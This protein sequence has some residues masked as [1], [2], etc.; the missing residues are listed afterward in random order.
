MIDRSGLKKVFNK[1][2]TRVN[3]LQLMPELISANPENRTITVYDQVISLADR[4]LYLIGSGK[5]STS[6]AL[7]IEQVAGAMLKGGMVVSTPDPLH[8]QNYTQVAYGS[9]PVP[10]Q[11]SVAATNELLMFIAGI[12]EES[13]VLNLVSGGTSSLL[14]K[15]ASDLTVDNIAPVYRLLL[16]SGAD[17]G[18]MNTVRKAM[19]AIKGGQL[20]T[21]LRHV[22]LIDLIISDVP[23]DNPEDI[24]SGPSIPQTISFIQ[25]ANILRKYDLTGKLPEK[26]RSFFEGGCNM[27]QHSGPALTQSSYHRS[28]IISSARKVAQH[29][30]QELKKLGYLTVLDDRPWTGPV[31]DLAEHI[32]S[33]LYGMDANTAYIFYGESTVEIKGNGLGGRN[34]ELALIMAKKLSGETKDVSFMSAGTDGID[35][36]TDAA[37]AIVDQTTWMEAAKRGLDPAAYLT[38]NDS[39][40]FFKKA[41][42]HIITGP[43]G[44]NVMDLQFLVV[45]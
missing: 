38:N 15:P 34:Q 26:V 42:G 13:L 18:E 28:F 16:E 33:K 24:G 35:G 36:P 29:A 8:K 27:E 44:N 9:H 20:L 25:A 6:M 31:Q 10:D 17:I 7:A 43:T 32:F 37:G 4:D 11:R 41:G 23:N 19:S 22:E 1:I 3:P 21:K 5:A 12:P 45:K 30:E 14:C 40:S 2:L 39:Y